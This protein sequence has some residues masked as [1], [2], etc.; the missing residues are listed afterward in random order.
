MKCV[1]LVISVSRLSL[2]LLKALE[3]LYSLPVT[4]KGLE[5]KGLCQMVGI[6][7]R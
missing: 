4:S 5:G 1:G 6:L 7:A 2:S 3:A